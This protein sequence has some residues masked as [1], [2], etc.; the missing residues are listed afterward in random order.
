LLVE[1]ASSSRSEQMNV[2]SSTRATSPGSE[3]AQNEPGRFAGSRATKVP[4]S[5]SCLQRSSRSAG[6]PSNQCTESGSQSRA[7]SSTQRIRRWCFV[8][9]F[10]NATD[11]PGKGRPPS[12]PA[13]PAGPPKRRC[14]LDLRAREA[15]VGLRPD[16][17]AGGATVV[18]EHE[19]HPLALTQHAEDGSVERSRREHV[20]GAV[21]VGDHHA[22]AGERV[23]DAYDALHAPA[24][25]QGFCTL[26]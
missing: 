10:T 11:P 20:V 5:T 25:G 7:I 4:A 6:E 26:P 22:L 17:D 12:L 8:G 16:A 15:H 24:L 18:V 3:R 1:P 2:R 14:R 21:L 9:G 13:T 19:V 23:V